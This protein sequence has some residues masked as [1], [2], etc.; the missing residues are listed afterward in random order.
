MKRAETKPGLHPRNRHRERYDFPRLVAAC[1]ELGPHVRVNPY[2]DP[3]IDFGD[4]RAVKALNRALL[5]AFYDVAHWDIPEGY[6][7]P[8]IPGRADLIHHLADLLASCNGG[9]IPQGATVRVLDIGVGAN[10]I[11]PILGHREYGWSFLGSDIDA[12]AL[13][14]A[15]RIVAENPGLA[16]AVE[17]RR[18]AHPP[19]ILEG[20]LK[21]GERFDLSLCNPP[22]HASAREAREGSERKWRNLGRATRNQPVRN[23]GGQGG[24]LWVPGG[25][26]AFLLRMIRESVAMPTACLWFTAL[27]S[28][29]GTLPILKR[30]LT[31]AEVA[32]IR[33][34]P[35]AQG[36]KKSR[37]LAWT[38]HG[39]EARE[40]WRKQRWNDA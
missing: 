36:Q 21:A 26:E 2:G 1:P 3:S 18:Q 8:P 31:Q 12:G 28:K 10:T 20:L 6:L 5:A 34:L 39:T 40:A 23:F 35:M 32:E 27:V 16:G 11:Y 29:T 4:P 9:A 14:N 37:I 38:F 30:A 15:R 22:F 24:E 19:R 25:E 33:T 17:I 13:A 7:C